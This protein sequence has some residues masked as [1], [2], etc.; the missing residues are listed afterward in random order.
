MPGGVHEHMRAW[1]PE[2]DRLI[3]EML[4]LHGPR[5][6]KIVK[7][8]PGRTISSVRN[9]W[10]RIDKGRRMSAAG[11]ESKNRC[12]WC[13][14]P[15]RGHVC[16]ARMQPRSPTNEAAAADAAPSNEHAEPD[17][18][19][20]KASSDIGHPASTRSTMLETPVRQHSGA[21]D[22]ADV[23]PS[24]SDLEEDG[25][26]EIENEE[27]P[28]VPIVCR[29]KSGARICE[30]LGF[31]STVS[32][33]GESTVPEQPSVV[34]VSRQSVSER[35]MPEVLSPSRMPSLGQLAP[36]LVG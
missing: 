1:E 6:G 32:A 7:E 22:L 20:D 36:T 34:P 23:L 11:A 5:W 19:T 35:S 8:L 2:E 21:S 33:S 12:Q 28:A 9:R 29:I 10:Q 13:G 3:I 4:S 27:P 30:E 31:E 14:Q 25:D 18:Q 17:A 15:K 24:A 26:E 16:F